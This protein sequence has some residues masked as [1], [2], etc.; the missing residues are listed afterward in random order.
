M[1][2]EINLLPEREPKKFAF[3]IV[4]SIIV[5]VILLGG[6]IYFLQGQSAKNQ[7]KTIDRQVSVVKKLIE[8]NTNHTETTSASNS[9]SQLENAIKWAKDY[10]IQTIPVMRKLTSLLPERGF[11]Q[12]FGYT[13]DGTVMLSA[14]FDSSRDAAY[15][16][17]NLTNS[18]WIEDVSLNSLTAQ[19]VKDPSNSAANTNNTAVTTNGTP[20]TVPGNSGATTTV[21]NTATGSQSAPPGNQS[22]QNSSSTGTNTQAV[23]QS[24]SQATMGNSTTNENLL[25]RYI[26][27]FEI[28]LNH[29]FVKEE[30]KKS[31]S[32]QEGGA[33]S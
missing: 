13:E 1:L 12:S 11:I 26:G 19:A 21:P 29:N 8:K 16:L 20:T 32:N 4:L 24:N 7:I 27:Q 15:F 18:Q 10:P 14:Q 6:V 3:L 5:A 22:N 9:A 23:D 28:K 30:I 31:T 2:V 17:T 25:P 33:G